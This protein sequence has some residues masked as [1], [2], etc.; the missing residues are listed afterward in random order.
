[1]KLALLIEDDYLNRKLLR[2]I[3]EIKFEVIETSSAEGALVLLEKHDP[4]VIFLDM[5]LPGMDGTTLLRQLKKN[6]RTVS[7][8]VIGVSARAF[9]DDIKQGRE[10]GCI[11]Y[12]TKPIEEDP[13]PFV[14]RMAALIEK[15]RAQQ[16]SLHG[17]KVEM[18]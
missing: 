9:P 10:Q 3:L 16:K 6:P 8:P 1:M 2:D 11:E 15:Y 12:V 14:E 18:N 5:Q 4:T 17:L 7:I 13:Q